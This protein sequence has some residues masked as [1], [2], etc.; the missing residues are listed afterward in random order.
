[1]SSVLSPPVEHKR[2]RFSQLARKK[3]GLGLN[4]QEQREFAT[5]VAELD[6]IPVSATPD[7][8]AA[9]AKIRERVD[10]SGADIS[11]LE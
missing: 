2:E 1:M 3:N 9:E 7:E 8:R 5:L 6:R 11:K 10:Q 4:D